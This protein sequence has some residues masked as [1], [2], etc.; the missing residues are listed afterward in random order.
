MDALTEMAAKCRWQVAAKVRLA[1]CKSDV[2]PTAL[3]EAIAASGAGAIVIAVME[4]RFGRTDDVAMATAA[5]A[6]AVGARL[7]CLCK[8][9]VD[10][11]KATADAWFEPHFVDLSRGV[12]AAVRQYRQ[13]VTSPTKNKFL[14][15]V[16]NFPVKKKPFQ[17]ILKII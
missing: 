2:Q 3:L 17:K 15:H 16:Q 4:D 1:Q 6:T 11:E 10:A 8:V 14:A 13:E 9:R 12:S 5:A 7:A